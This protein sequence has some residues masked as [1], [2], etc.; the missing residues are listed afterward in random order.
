M[1]CL[2]DHIGRPG[3]CFQ[4]GDRSLQPASVL[5][6]FTDMARAL[7]GDLELA[8]LLSVARL[9]EA[10]YSAQVRRDVSERTQREQTVGAVHATLQRLE[11]KKLVRSSMS[12]A[13]PV[14]GG[15]ARRCYRIT[16]AGERAIEHAHAVNAAIWDGAR[17]GWRTV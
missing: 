10:A 5:L 6:S 13:T 17:K 15:R 9:D 3:K 11:N 14:R 16:A 4:H 2:I 7:L 8:V 1:L 12:D